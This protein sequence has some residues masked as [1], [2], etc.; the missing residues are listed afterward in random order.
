[1]VYAENV[2]YI[3]APDVLVQD[4]EGEAVLLNLANELY[5]GLDEVGYRMYTLI[6]T[7]ASLN[8]AYQALSEEYE[9][10]PDQLQQDFDKLVGE[11]VAAGLITRVDE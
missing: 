1:M 5:F 7:S 10:E 3:K 6:T 11:L 4:L 9:V 2:Q 8:D